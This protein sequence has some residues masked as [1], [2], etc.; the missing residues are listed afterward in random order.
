MS[1]VWLTD[2]SNGSKVAVNPKYV[3]AVFTPSE[4]PA[5]GK[6]VISLINGTIPVVENEI[7]VV[8]QFGAAE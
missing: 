5:E 6:T 2:A 4:G 7:D 3:V 1:L 8:A